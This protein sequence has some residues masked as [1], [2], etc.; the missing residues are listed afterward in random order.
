M[1]A[2]PKLFESSLKKLKFNQNNFFCLNS[3]YNTVPIHKLFPVLVLADDRLANN[4][5]VVQ[6][7]N[8]NVF[9]FRFRRQ[10][11]DFHRFFVVLN[12]KQTNKVE[13]IKRRF[14][15]VFSKSKST[16]TSIIFASSFLMISVTLRFP[17]F[18]NVTMSSIFSSCASTCSMSNFPEYQTAFSPISGS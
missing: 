16:F 17:Q 9:H 11:S 5:I 15:T 8:E 18:T 4:V 6:T 14:L 3:T 7:F 12:L 1:P 2:R 10:P 13:Q